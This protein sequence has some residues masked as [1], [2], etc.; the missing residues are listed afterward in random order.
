MCYRNDNV[1][2]LYTVRLTYGPDF[3]IH[4]ETED[5]TGKLAT[6]RKHLIRKLTDKT[7]RTYIQIRIYNNFIC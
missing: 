7:T 3:I 4:E 6:I 1:Q 2:S 5:A